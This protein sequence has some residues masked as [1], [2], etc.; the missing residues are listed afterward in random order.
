[1]QGIR[2]WLWMCAVAILST[3][4]LAQNYP[5]RPLR[6]IIPYTP[7]GA[8]DIIGRAVANKLTETLGQ[9]VLVDNRPGANTIVGAEIASKASPDGYTLFFGTLPTLVLNPATY[10]K[11]PYDP[12]KD[13][14]SVAKLSEY[15]YFIVARN[16]FPAKN[17]AE[18]VAYAKANPGKVT[19]GSTGEGSP[20]HL[21]GVLLESLAGIKMVHIPYKGNSVTN[22]DLMGERLDFTMTGLPSIESLVKAGKLRLIASTG[23]KRDPLYPEVATVDES[24]FPGYAVRTWFAIVT[25][26]GTPRAIILRLNSEINRALQS[27]EVQKPLLDSGYELAK[28][29]PE[30]LDQL[31]RDEIPRWTRVAR[32]ANI[33]FD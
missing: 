1:M 28:G 29:T 6:L 26:A 25:R 8:T 19:Y 33:S 4:T 21:G 2:K 24:G 13:F 3:N 31:I 22:L 5:N 14:A 15:F 7:G 10:K 16:G 12:L 27:P 32:E 30:D 18:L 23:L 9:S 17:I 20:S 11:L